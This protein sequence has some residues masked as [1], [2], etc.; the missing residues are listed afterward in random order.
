MR[1]GENDHLWGTILLIQ[2]ED[3][4]TISFLMYKHLN[5]KSWDKLSRWFL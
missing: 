3:L 2:N 1:T 5:K 4:K